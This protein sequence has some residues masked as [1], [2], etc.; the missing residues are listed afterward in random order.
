MNKRQL[1]E[2]IR[3]HNITAQPGF[4]AQFDEDALRQYL[5][6]ARKKRARFNTSQRD[7]ADM[8]M[9]S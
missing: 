6:E 8:R 3:K 1:I 4:L 2:E 7:D 5:E 9:V